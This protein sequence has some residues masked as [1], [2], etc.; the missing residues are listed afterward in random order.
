VS[1]AVTHTANVSSGSQA[2]VGS[3]RMDFIARTAGNGQVQTLALVNR[4]RES[5]RSML[6]AS[7]CLAIP[8]KRTSLPTSSEAVC[9]PRARPL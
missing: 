9:Q 5:R 8:G 2:A 4:G 1:D 3:P 7:E 6:I